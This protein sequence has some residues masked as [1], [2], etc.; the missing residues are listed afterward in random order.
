MGLAF[1]EQAID[2]KKIVLAG[3]SLGAAAAGQAVSQHSFSKDRSYIVISQMS[4][5]SVTNI[6]AQLTN[7]LF[8]SL[9]ASLTTKGCNQY[10]KAFFAHIGLFVQ[11]VAPKIVQLAGCEM[12]VVN[13]SKKLQ[14]EKIQHIIIQS[15]LTTNPEKDDDIKGDGVIPKKASLS[16]TLLQKNIQKTK[17]FRGIIDGT[18]SNMCAIFNATIPS[19]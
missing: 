14:T 12:D 4:F 10:I 8:F 5:D 16:Y 3:Y 1:L 13:A 19:L 9:N 11:W 17:V 15:S 7:E 6:T 18:H 2:A